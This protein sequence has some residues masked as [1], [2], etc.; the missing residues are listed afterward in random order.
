MKTIV[1][2]LTTLLAGSIAG[3]HGGGH[4][5]FAD[6]KL[7]AHLSWAQGPDA[8]GGESRMRLEWHDGSN[9]EL[10]EPG[11]PFAVKLWMPAM[12]HGSAP[13]KIAPMKN[14]RGEA[15]LGTYLVSNMYFTMPGDWEIRITVK[16]AD[17][18]QETKAWAVNLEGDGHGGHHDH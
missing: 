15:L 9:H 1:L 8:Q 6:G 13:T 12:G 17:G 18:R 4:L 5:A 10:L 3:A 14:E 16:H 11:L 2:I 7:H